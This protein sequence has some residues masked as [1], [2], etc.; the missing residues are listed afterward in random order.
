M[1]RQNTAKGASKR[2]S[3]VW[4]ALLLCSAAA[5]TGCNNYCVSGVI[6]PPTGTIQV[7]T[8]PPSQANATVR[9]RIHPSATSSTESG[10]IGFLVRR[11]RGACW[12][13][14]RGALALRP[15]ATR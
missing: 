3:A 1:P 13:L 5:T 7:N 14:P 11:D 2:F 9:I 8:C 10:S 4:L 15:A 6:N 12:C